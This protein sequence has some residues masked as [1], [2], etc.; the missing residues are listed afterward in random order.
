V[1]GNGWLLVPYRTITQVG[2]EQAEKLLKFGFQF[3]IKL[4]LHK[5]SH[6]DVHIAP[7]QVTP[8]NMPPQGIWSY[9]TCFESILQ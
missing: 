5:V 6:P 4:V 1:V 7:Q 8:S 2:W 3:D 9:G